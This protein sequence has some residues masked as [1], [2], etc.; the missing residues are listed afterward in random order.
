MNGLFAALLG[1]ILMGM[2]PAPINTW[3][4]AWVALVPLWILILNSERS[5]L[6]STILLAVAW[7]CGYHGLALFWITG[8]HPMTW[9]GVSW[10]ASFLIALF[11]WIFITFWGV[12]LVVAWS[13]IMYFIGN[14]KFR[15]K[16]NFIDSSLR[17]II[18]VALWC[19]LEAIWSRGSLWWTS[20]S[21]TQSPANLAILQLSQISGSA[22]I[23]AAIVTVNGA[24]AEILV[25]LKD[26]RR[27][28]WATISWLFLP[29]ALYFAFYLLGFQL[30]S[31]PL[32]D[33]PENA[34]KIGLI[35]GN[36]PNEIKLYPAGWGKAIEGY[37]SGYKTLSKLGVDII[38]TPETALPFPWQE[39]IQNS[40]FYTAILEGKTV[41]LVGA[42]GKQNR[43]LTNSLFAVSSNGLVLSQYD[44]VNLVPLGEY[45]PLEKFLGKFIGRL[46]PLDAHL[47]AGNYHQ[48]FDTPFGRAIV[49]ICYDSAFSQ[50]FR[51]QTVAGGEFIVT[52]A[53]NAHYSQAMPAQHHAQDILRAIETN[54]WLA[55]ATNTGYSAIVNPKGE[56]IWI[57][58]IN[59]YELHEDTIYRRRTQTLYVKWGDWLT[60]VLIGLGIAAI[61]NL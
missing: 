12:L 54:R 34:I 28:I 29:L 35:Q 17:V 22:T 43:S 44:K 15:K 61:I 19:G 59:T 25:Y 1:G 8:I 20:L 4:F 23:V 26:S 50:H 33:M 11:C 9:M 5:S 32:K 55:R 52:A 38:L 56:T 47:A 45:I 3:Y 60:L 58:G 30:Y 46:S 37:T 53:N 13:I 10:I 16:I 24:I 21:Y 27:S 31:L 40:S 48:K 14:L 49:G 18:G 42:F 7:G 41:A 6:N 57:S 51:R 36:I 39:I 2:T